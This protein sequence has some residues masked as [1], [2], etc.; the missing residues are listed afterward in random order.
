MD[1]KKEFI[2]YISELIKEE[3]E[4]AVKFSPLADDPTCK[5]TVGALELLLPVDMMKAIIHET[6]P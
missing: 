3:G 5:I 2:K 6:E 1:D 4:F